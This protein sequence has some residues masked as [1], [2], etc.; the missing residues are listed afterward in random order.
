MTMAI[1]GFGRVCLSVVKHGPP[2]DVEWAAWLALLRE[3]RGPQMRVV[4]ETDSGP[5]AAQRRALAE[6]LHGVDVSFAIMTDSI[7][8][9][10]IVTALA[11][12][13]V[14]HCAFPLGQVQQATAYLGLTDDEALRTEQELARLQREVLRA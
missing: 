1:A 13:G 12:L 2:T 11:W 14:R 4:V 3:H 10:G 7:V 8:V 9:R 5:N 6:T